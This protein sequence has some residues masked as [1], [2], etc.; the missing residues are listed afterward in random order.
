[1]SARDSAVTPSYRPY[2]LIAELTYLCP[3][4]CAYCSN[5]LDYNNYPDQLSTQDWLRVF[6]DAEQI[7][8]LQVNLSG[9]E[10]LLRGDLPRLVQG[11]S[12]ANLYVNLITSGIPADKDILA[13]L[14]DEGLNSV[15]ISIQDSEPDTSD[16]IAGRASFTK[17][18]QAAKWVK[19]LG[20][21]LTLNVV[22]HRENLGRVQSIVELAEQLGADRLELANAQYLAW[23]LVNRESLLPTREQLDAARNLATAA[24]QRLRGKME[25]LFV[26][27]DYY[28]D[29]PKACMSGWGQRY[30]VVRPDGVAM[31][32]HLAHTIRELEFDNV[33]QRPLR[34]IWDNSKAFQ[35]FRGQDWLPEPCRSCERRTVDFGGCRC[36]AYQL[37]GDARATDP[38]CSLAPEHSTV[39]SAREA[40]RGPIYPVSLTYRSAL[41]PSQV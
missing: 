34:E 24:K 7:G 12:V 32:C 35:A 37:T 17:K 4:R 10:P 39:M 31:P 8:V 15:Q 20:L 22:L 40:A 5:P 33:L 28:S 14:R 36:Q 30:I 26:L 29:V 19:E 23:A 9:G 27:P 16:R 1:V 25:V 2:A 41:R 18:I 6:R 13:K 21:P 11:A 38:V 3:L